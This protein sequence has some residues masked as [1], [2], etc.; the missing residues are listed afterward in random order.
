M[1]DILELNQKMVAE[2]RK[3]AE[4]L[5]I[6]NIDNLNKGDLVYRIL[7]QQAIIA[8]TKPAKQ[9]PTAQSTNDQNKKKRKRR[10]STEKVDY[11]QNARQDRVVT[12]STRPAPPTLKEFNAPKATEEIQPEE[13]AMLD[14]SQPAKVENLEASKQKRKRGRPKKSPH[15]AQP[16]ILQTLES[17]PADI[18]EVEEDY[19]IIEEVVA[20]SEP[21]PEPEIIKPIEP[22]PER[23]YHQNN[24]KQKHFKKPNEDSYEN[25]NQVDASGVLEIMQGWLWIPSFFRFQ[26]FE[27]T[28]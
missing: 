9:K 6:T 5:E 17:A 14:S 19:P 16:S 11:Q 3:I 8:S 15:T 23:P 13:A 10:K 18:L 24:H 27:F 2:L 7:D 20:I 28:G 26:L 1:Y 4:E 22:T 12:E 21:E 25:D